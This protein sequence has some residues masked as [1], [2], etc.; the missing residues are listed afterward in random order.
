MG[1]GDTVSG[2]FGLLPRANLS[3]EASLAQFQF[4][5][6]L[7]S[8]PLIQLRHTCSVL[9]VQSTASSVLPIQSTGRSVLPIQSKPEATCPFSLLTAASCP[10]SI[11]PTA[12][13]QLSLWQTKRW[14]IRVSRTILKQ[15]SSWNLGK[16]GAK[17]GTKRRHHLSLT[18]KQVIK[19]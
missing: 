1:T 3:S 18:I 17:I 11:L 4:M 8:W 6:L 16:K 9:P 14:W 12:S 13:W 7:E 19:L 15:P 2:L 5:L 10:F